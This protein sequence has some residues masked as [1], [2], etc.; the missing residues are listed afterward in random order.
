MHNGLALS[1]VPS[2]NHY[3][4]IKLDWRLLSVFETIPYPFLFKFGLCQRG[5][6]NSLEGVCWRQKELAD[7]TVHLSVHCVVE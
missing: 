6:Y 5:N 4:N 2:L 3:F 7:C 1:M